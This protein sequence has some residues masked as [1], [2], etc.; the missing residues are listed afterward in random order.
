VR[1]SL[2][3]AETEQSDNERALAAV[4]IKQ[5]IADNVASVKNRVA[6]AA[7]KCGRSPSE[8]TIVAVTKYVDAEMTQMLLDAGLF[9]LGENRPQQLWDKASAL[10]DRGIRW[11]Q[12]GHLQRN[13]LKRTLPLI[14]LLHAGDSPRLL[15]A[16]DEGAREADSKVSVLLEVNISEDESKHGFTAT[17]LARQMPE[18]SQLNNIRIVGLM[19]MASR[20][21]GL[22][23]AQRDFAALAEL[24]ETLRSACPPNVEL[25]ELSMGMSGDFEVAIAEGSTIVRV[26]SAFF[27]GVL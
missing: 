9:D 13:K 25:R 19:G 10:Q 11:H 20:E 15:T 7:V 18:M 17:E 5:K 2:V 4:S 23:S 1:I 27:D 22:D 12:I 8:I 26:G 21:G 16:V 14:H 6:E 3:D 24:R